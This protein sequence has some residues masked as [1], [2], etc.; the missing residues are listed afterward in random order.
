MPPACEAPARTEPRHPACDP[1]R[2]ETDRHRIAIRAAI[3]LRKNPVEHERRGNDSQHEDRNEH[4][5]ENRGVG[6]GAAS[7]SSGQRDPTHTAKRGRADSLEP[8]L[9]LNPWLDVRH[10]MFDTIDDYFRPCRDRHAIE[11]IGGGLVA[12][13]AD[14]IHDLSMLASGDR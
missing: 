3:A 9:D 6:H 8:L 2:L 7:F 10:A 5:G 11:A 4:D 12:F 14:D 13:P 1:A